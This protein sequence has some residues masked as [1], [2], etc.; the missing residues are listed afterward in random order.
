M[1]APSRPT[2]GMPAA[3]LLA[4]LGALLTA[5]PA[6]AQVGF[7]L[8]LNG[9][10]FLYYTPQMVPSTTDFLYDHAMRRAALVGA[11]AQQQADQSLRSSSRAYWN[12]LRDTSGGSSY[13]L[14]TRR[15]LSQRAGATA[16]T[17]P[18]APAAP[19][20]PERPKVLSLD[21]FF[22]ASGELDWP[23]D[24]TALDE[25]PLRSDRSAADEALKR[26]REELHASGSA[27][28]QSIAAARHG[29]ITYGQQALARIR[30]ERSPAVADVFHYFL[31]FLND[32]IGDLESGP[33]S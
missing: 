2:R 31:L 21:A 20:V 19:A 29:L 7:A 23:R 27:S 11:A 30:A 32:T 33:A 18:A 24:A 26:L 9:D 28:A 25:G 22:V 16:P 10:P 14:S 5:Q 4:L 12:R 3:A 17:T 6:R 13:D 8:G 1:L 15:S